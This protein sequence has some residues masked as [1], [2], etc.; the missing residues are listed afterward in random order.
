MRLLFVRL[1]TCTRKRMPC[2]TAMAAFASRVVNAGAMNAPL[3]VL[4]RYER[5]VPARE[6][7]CHRGRRRVL[8]G[9]IHDHRRSQDG[10]H[11]VKRDRLAADDVPSGIVNVVELR[12]GADAVAAQGGVAAQLQPR[13]R[14]LVK[15]RRPRLLVR[16]EM[17]ARLVV[18]QLGEGV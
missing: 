6:A 13:Y 4:S 15:I 9:L 16:V 18:A 11:V 14:L 5:P 12:P 2:E 17:P 7:E 1:L 8:D 3:F 10:I